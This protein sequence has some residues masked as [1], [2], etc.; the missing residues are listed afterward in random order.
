MADRIHYLMNEI[1]PLTDESLHSNKN[2]KTDGDLTEPPLLS[3][4]SVFLI[5][6]TCSKSLLY[7]D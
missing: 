6:F 3:I 5:A 1:E 2:G 7:L 4:I